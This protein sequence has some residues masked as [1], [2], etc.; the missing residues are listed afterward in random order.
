MNTKTDFYELLNL[1]SYPMQ[2]IFRVT[3]MII[4]YWNGNHQNNLGWHVSKYF[5]IGYV[6]HHTQK[7][8]YEWLW[9]LILKFINVILN[10]SHIE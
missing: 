2:P 3:L 8:E 10:V 1:L 4:K 5:M 7:N 9:W 6:T